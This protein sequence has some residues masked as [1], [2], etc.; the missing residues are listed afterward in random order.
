[1]S[2]KLLSFRSWTGASASGAPWPRSADALRSRSCSGPSEPC[3]RPRS[4][5]VSA[6]SRSRRVTP[7]SRPRAPG[8]RRRAHRLE[9]LLSRRAAARARPREGAVR[10]V[11]PIS[12][13]AQYV[14]APPHRRRRPLAIVAVSSPAQARQVRAK[15]CKH[16]AVRV[17]LQLLELAL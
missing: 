7:P 1:L 11:T 9:W 10:G 17:P 14:Q 2:R 15:G 16:V 8:T 13:L 6:S 12:H 3:T 5:T 4:P